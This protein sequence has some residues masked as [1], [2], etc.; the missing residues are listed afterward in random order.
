VIGILPWIQ[1]VWKTSKFCKDARN[2]S[3]KETHWV[4]NNLSS[5]ILKLLE[6]N[7]T[8]N[9][10]G[11]RLNKPVPWRVWPAAR[12]KAMTPLRS[13]ITVVINDRYY[14]TRMVSFGEGEILY[15]PPRSLNILWQ[16]FWVHCSIVLYN[17]CRLSRIIRF[18]NNLVTQQED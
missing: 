4:W 8:Y 9:L 6:E 17:I 7:V 14:Y 5:R 2:S 1:L 11:L 3:I 12:D 10:F 15:F 16:R 18:G 13:H